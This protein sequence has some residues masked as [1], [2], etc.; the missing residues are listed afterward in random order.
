MMRWERAARRWYSQADRC[1]VSVHGAARE[2]DLRS[3]GAFVLPQFCSLE[4]E[5]ALVKAVY[6]RLAAG[7]VQKD[8][9]DAVIA[10]YREVA[11]ARKSAPPACAGVLERLSTLLEGRQDALQDDF[12]ALE[13][14]EDGEIRPHVRAVDWRGA[15]LFGGE[16]EV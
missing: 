12:H 10:N 14:A 11:I 1:M 15:V 4:E 9:F 5:V 8:H 3:F 6:P 16:W 2:L 7:E 13:L